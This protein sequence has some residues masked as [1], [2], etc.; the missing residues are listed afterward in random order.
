MSAR[1]CVISLDAA[2]ATLIERWAAEG[3]LPVLGALAR[4]GLVLRLAN[5]LETLPG[6]IWPE[7]T[8]GRSGGRLARFYH[9]RKLHTGD[10]RFRPIS[11]EEVDASQYYW[12]VASAAGRRVAVIDQP[13]AALCRGLDGIQ[14]LGW[15]SHDRPFPAQAEPGSLLT[16]IQSRFG[17]YPVAS[18][19]A[20]D[21]TP[22]GY[23]TLLDDLLGAVERRTAVL[24]DL[25]ARESWDLFTCAFTECHCVGH[26]FWG[27]FADAE[28]REVPP[29]LREAIQRVYARVDGA[30]GRIIEGAGAG[31]AVLVVA[32]H[33]MGPK[34]GGTQLL[35]EFLL[36]LGLG[37]GRGLATQARSWL[38]RRF[39]R[40]VRRMAPAGALRGLQAAAGSLPTPLESPRTRA[41]AV[42][43]NRCGAIRLNLRGREPHGG[44]EPGGEADALLA[45][46]RREL[47]ALEHLATGERIV[48]RVVTAA[49]A[50]G[51]DHHPD[52]PDLI[53]VFRT[54]LGPL[55]A[56]RSDRVGVIRE[57]FWGS[58]SGDHT[59]ESRLW[60]L[61]TERPRE[62]DLP[63]NVVDL[64]P[65]VL[66]LLD[67]ARPPGLDGRA[68]LV[69]SAPPLRV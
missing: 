46:M 64:A 34:I 38:P 49:E 55:E 17:V 44:V 28:G 11:T 33:G 23:R 59:T 16:E 40:L 7:L 43:N 54:D 41:I 13:Q 4:D 57:P 47:L 45:E 1:V 53:V 62:A 60:A 2:E 31:A 36:R 18:C 10:T 42:P 68:L 50:Y 27:F 56:C 61:G 29:D 48:K 15:G 8:T 52:L 35:P 63:A 25:M 39:R 9:S 65:T 67:V 6:S 20:R 14:L 32:S 30:V 51:P 22:E 24:L 37:S 66:R 58:R 26:Q 69:P 21:K 12:S 19:D 5:C 3:Q